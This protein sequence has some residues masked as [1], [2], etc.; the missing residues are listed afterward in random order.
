MS[1]RKSKRRADAGVQVP[2]PPCEAMLMAQAFL[3]PQW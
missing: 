1:L 3:P 2:T